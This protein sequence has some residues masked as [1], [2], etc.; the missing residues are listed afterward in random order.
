MWRT[1]TLSGCFERPL[2][3]IFTHGSVRTRF[4]T[5]SRVGRRAHSATCPGITDSPIHFQSW[6]RNNMAADFQD[7]TGTFPRVPKGEMGLLFFPS[8]SILHLEY[9]ILLSQTVPSFLVE[10]GIAL[11]TSKMPS[12]C[13]QRQESIATAESTTSR[14]LTH[15]QKFVP[16]AHSENNEWPA[17]FKDF[18][19]PYSRTHFPPRTTILHHYCHVPDPFKTP[20]R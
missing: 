7:A 13:G 4:G 12:K 9:F 17:S 19:L 18:R 2:P 16:V 15:G 8:F 5:K 3:Q 6:T 14:P 11:E 10:Y 20:N 1:F